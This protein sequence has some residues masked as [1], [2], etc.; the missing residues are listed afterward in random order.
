MPEATRPER[1]WFPLAA[2]ATIGAIAIG[3]LQVVT[4]DRVGSPGGD[5]GS[6]S[7]A[8]PGA[9]GVE[10]PA[11]GADATPAVANDAFAGD[12]DDGGKGVGG[13]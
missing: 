5:A 4:P 6:V 3:L 9:E 7:D 1:W 2:A 10:M 8:V 12:G 13:G 11:A